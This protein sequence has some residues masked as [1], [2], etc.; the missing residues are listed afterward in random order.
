MDIKQMGDIGVERV[1]WSPARVAFR[2]EQ[3][4]DVV[5]PVAGRVL[6]LQAQIGDTVQ[7]GT[8]LAIISSPDASRIRADYANA[9]VDLRVAQAEAARQ[10]LMMEKGIGVAVERLAAEAKLQQA[11]HQLEATSRAASFLGAGGSDQLALKSPRAGVVVARTAAVGAA[12]GPDAGSLFTVGDPNALWINADVFESDLA[13]IK[14][15]AP[16]QV[17]VPSLDQPLA[18]KV[19][20]VSSALDPQTRRGTVYITLENSNNKLRAGMLAR[21]G[22]QIQ[23]TGGLMLPLGAVLIKDGDSSIVYVQ[24]QDTVFESRK[25]VLGSPSNGYIPVLAGLN[26]GDKVVVRG[27]LLLDGSAGQLL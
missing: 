27:A 12:V 26:P 3:V 14:E 21:A 10:K 11:E 8:P 18:G 13:N 16:V 7:V 25:V 9:Q 4:S 5:A 2:Q 6:Q 1:V 20:R 22:I 15:G 24:V 23:G 17:S 19:T